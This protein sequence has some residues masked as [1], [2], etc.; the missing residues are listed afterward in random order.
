PEG[1]ANE[2]GTPSGASSNVTLH[3]SMMPCRP[4]RREGA[5]YGRRVAACDDPMWS[6]DTFRLSTIVARASK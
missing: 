6:D 1:L 3:G 5:V 2:T 4:F